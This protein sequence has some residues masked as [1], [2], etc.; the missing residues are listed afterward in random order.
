ML[1]HSVNDWNWEP[2]GTNRG[3]R[4]DDGGLY[5]I[6]KRTGN[7]LKKLAEEPTSQIPYKAE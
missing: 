2:E 3:K 5:E 6:R 7:G 1:C 4:K